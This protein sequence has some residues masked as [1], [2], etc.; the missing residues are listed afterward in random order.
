MKDQRQHV[1]I[2]GCIKQGHRIASGSNSNSPYPAGSIELQKPF[3]KLFGLDLSGY[4]NGTL[5]VDISPKRFA[6]VSPDYRFR[7]VKWI[8]GFAPEDFSFVSCQLEFRSQ[9]YSGWLYYPHPETKTQHFHDDSLLE[10]LMPKISEI[11]Y[12]DLV[13]LKIDADKIN[14]SA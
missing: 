9:I 14:V 11:G 7:K 5:N 10:V 6:L 1:L 4:F 2:Q 3:F 13:E 8:A 12:G